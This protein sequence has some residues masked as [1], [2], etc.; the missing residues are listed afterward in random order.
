MEALA[1][2]NAENAD[3][4]KLFDSLLLDGFDLLGASD[5]L[6]VIIGRSFAVVGTFP[7]RSI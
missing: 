7:I 3:R 5:R 2:Y 6:S 4:N 1:V